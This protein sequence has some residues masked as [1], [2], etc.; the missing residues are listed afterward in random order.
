MRDW[1]PAESQ[2][3]EVSMSGN[4]ITIKNVR[5]HIWKSESE[6]TP[7]YYDRTYNLDEIE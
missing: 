5:N 7:G 3:S 6:F 2:L 1:L 4:L